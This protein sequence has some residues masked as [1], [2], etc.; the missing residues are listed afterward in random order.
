MASDAL[1]RITFPSVVS[2]PTREPA[3]VPA[4][5]P[6]QHTPLVGRKRE[7][8]AVRSL[9]ARGNVR[10]L[11]LTG[12]G[13][14]GKTRLAI[15][16]A[17]Q[18]AG[19]FANRVA[20][21]SLAA[22]RPPEPVAPAILRALGGREARGEI[23]AERLHR[24]LGAGAVLLVLDN[25]EHLLAEAMVVTS[26]LEACSRLTILVTSRVALRLSGEREF[27]VPPLALPDVADT[28]TAKSALRADAV[29]LFVQ[30]AAAARP[31]FAPTGTDLAAIAA[32]C[33]RLD[34]LPLAIE[35][36]AARVNHLSPPALRDDLDLLASGVSPA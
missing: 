3:L 17:E 31:G 9:L 32:I 25:V 20:F 26:L 30:R 2:F 34:G 28:G 14:V 24:L 27:A 35:L 19:T 7:L 23:V 33:Q 29:R 16:A 22:I 12:P 6:P 11:T 4:H 18:V 5:L 10:L 8:A 15:H 1:S 21:V 36:A 13:G